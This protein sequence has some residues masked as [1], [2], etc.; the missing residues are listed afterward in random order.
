MEGTAMTT[1]AGILVIGFMACLAPLAEH[2]ASR[3]LPPDEDGPVT[4][5]EP[6]PQRNEVR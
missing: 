3:W 1:A 2:L 6:E 4:Y 5:P